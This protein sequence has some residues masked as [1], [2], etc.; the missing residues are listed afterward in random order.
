MFKINIYF[1]HQITKKN[2]KKNH[3]IDSFF[4]SKMHTCYCVVPVSTLYRLWI[5]TL[6]IQKIF[7]FQIKHLI[8]M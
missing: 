4:K 6:V 7:N 1:S 5:E 8:T 3:V 2:H